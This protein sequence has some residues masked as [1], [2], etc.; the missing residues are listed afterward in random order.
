MK[1][2]VTD[3]GVALESENDAEALTL[4][5]FVFPKTEGKEVRKHKK[6]QHKKIC[7]LCTKQFKGLKGLNSHRSRMHGIRSKKYEINKRFYEGR[8]VAETLSHSN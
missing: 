6:H 5:R 3:T 4:F 7:D 8:K 2:S 1:L